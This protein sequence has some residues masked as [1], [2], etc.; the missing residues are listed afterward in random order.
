LCPL[1]DLFSTLLV[2][3]KS[4]ARRPHL[5]SHQRRRQEYYES[6]DTDL[7]AANERYQPVLEDPGGWWQRV[8]R[9]RYPILFKI[10]CDYLTIPCTSC[11]CERCFSS[12]GARQTITNDRNGLTGTTVE[13][14]QLQ[15]NWLRRG[16]VK[17]SILDLL[18]SVTSLT[19]ISDFG[20]VNFTKIAPSA[21]PA[22]SLSPPANYRPLTVVCGQCQ[23]YLRSY[24]GYDRTSYPKL[25]HG[26]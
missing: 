19:K 15:K 12:A 24:Y 18:K 11:D 23:Q 20:S 10:A 17:S 2:R 7:N 25:H 6:L 16:K 21:L 1:T 8:G 9:N 22:P 13:A 26:T 14:L 5:Q 4:P 3:S